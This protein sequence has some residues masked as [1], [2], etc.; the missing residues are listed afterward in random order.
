[1]ENI[2]GACSAETRRT[3][4][5]ISADEALKVCSTPWLQFN[6]HSM[7]SQ[8]LRLRLFDIA[9]KQKYE[10]LESFRIISI[11][12]QQ[13]PV[14]T[15]SI[16]AYLILQSTLVTLSNKDPPNQRSTM[17]A[18]AMTD[19]LCLTS[20]RLSDLLVY[21]DTTA[22]LLQAVHG[23]FSE[24]VK[25]CS[26]VFPS[27]VQLTIHLSKFRGSMVQMFSLWWRISHLNPFF[28]RGTTLTQR[29][30]LCRIMGG[31]VVE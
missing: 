1:M 14:C 30:S 17:F 22:E 6:V 16:T 7:K 20:T 13:I 24:A 2:S 31:K 9:H 27:E 5:S 10:S 3:Q 29:Q 28:R 19:L 15:Y 8:A 26:P 4:C 21:G 18:I 25:G 12:A 23:E 11:L